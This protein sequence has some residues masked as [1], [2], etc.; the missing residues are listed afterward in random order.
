MP[1]LK[2]LSRN[3]E[4][5]VPPA[6]LEGILRRGRR[7]RL[8]KV[9]SVTGATAVVLAAALVI[10]VVARPGQSSGPAG[11]SDTLPALHTGLRLLPAAPN[12]AAQGHPVAVQNLFHDGGRLYA[13]VTAGA[14]DSWSRVAPRLQDSPPS[15]EVRAV[16]QPGAEDCVNPAGIPRAVALPAEVAAAAQVRDL[17]S[18]T[19]LPVPAAHEGTMLPGDRMMVLAAPPAGTELTR[20]R[21]EGLRRAEGR[22]YAVVTAGQC[23]GWGRATVQPGQRVEVRIGGRP[24]PIPCAESGHPKAVAL[25]GNLTGSITDVATGR[26]L[27]VPE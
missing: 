6:E 12:D 20:V 14:C 17:V 3:V 21:I 2:S 16:V 19:A 13:L 1:D 25:P 22:L 5:A 10:P 8:R 18:G 23:D 24:T 11:R 4:D 7:R 27:D 15:I 9:I 26:V